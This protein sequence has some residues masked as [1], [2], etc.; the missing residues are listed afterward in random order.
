MAGVEPVR[1]WLRELPEDDRLKIGTDLAT[2][3]FGWPIG[4]PVCRSLGGGLW[5]VR[6]KLP[7]RRIARV[8]FFVH[9]NRRGVVHGFIKKTEK[10]LQDDLEL[11]HKRMREM[12]T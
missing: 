3:Q 4:M 12:E 6:S 9:K 10:A 11:A 1:D 5:E 8:L 7:S 2:V